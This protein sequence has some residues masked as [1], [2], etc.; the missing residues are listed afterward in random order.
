MQAI[1]TD[2]AHK[3]IGPYSQ[4]LLAGDFLYVSGQLPIE[5]QSGSVSALEVDAQ[6]RQVLDNIQSI[7]KIAGA[8]MAQVVRTTIFIKDMY[9]F[10][11]VNSVYAQYFSDPYPTRS[12]VEVARLP[13]DVLVEIDAVAY[14]G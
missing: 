7:L 3:V 13:K 11:K 14:V 1:Q 9:D 12:C 10:P 4:G 2:N 8:S 6:T 5:P